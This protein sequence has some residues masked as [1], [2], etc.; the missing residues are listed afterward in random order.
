MDSVYESVVDPT[1]LMT[2]GRN[3]S[4]RITRLPTA[5]A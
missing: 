1:S 3:A 2:S 4:P 5:Q